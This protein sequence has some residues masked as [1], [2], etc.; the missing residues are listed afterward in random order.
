M[1]YFEITY[2]WHSR[3]LYRKGRLRR[4]AFTFAGENVTDAYKL[5]VEEGKKKFPRHKWQVVACREIQFGGNGAEFSVEL[6][7]E[8]CNA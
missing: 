6:L 5:A 7:K 1:R 2:E 3:P 4:D 8:T